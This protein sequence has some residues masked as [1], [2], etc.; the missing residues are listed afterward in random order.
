MKNSF[1]I[2][3]TIVIS[4]ITG[5]PA[6]AGYFGMITDITGKIE[7]ISKTNDHSS[8]LLGS[9]FDVNDEFKLSKNSSITI[10]AHKNCEELLIQGAG[11]IKINAHAIEIISGAKN[12]IS[13]I[14]ELPVC[15]T[16]D[17]INRTKTIGGLILRGNSDPVWELR[18]EFNDDGNASNATLVTLIAYDLDANEIE[19]ARPYFARLKSKMPNSIF[20]QDIAERFSK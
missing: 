10:V 3:T 20:I 4:L 9:N 11:H 1:L 8:D 14:R 15:Y 12:M 19:R 2:L 5:S 17:S 7:H 6:W 13:F 16:P 18:K